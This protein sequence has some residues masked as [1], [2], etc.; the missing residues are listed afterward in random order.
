MKKVI[1]LLLALLTLVFAV[2]V[3]AQKGGAEQASATLRNPAGDVIGS[4]RLTE[5]ATGI[6]H[7]NV[8][9]KGLAPGLHGIHIH[10]TGSCRPSFAAAGGHHNPQGHEHGLENPQG[11]HAGDLPNIEIDENGNAI[12]EATTDRIDLGDTGEL[13]IFDADGSALIIHAQPDDQMTSPAGNSG[14][15]II[16]GV[17]RPTSQM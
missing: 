13:A 1:S 15:R 17:I 12:Y 16:C 7:V 2:N 10:A 11:P 14:D 9:V 8:H 4:A 6:V 3:Y 5:D